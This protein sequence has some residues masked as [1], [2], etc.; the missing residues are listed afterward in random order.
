[1]EG[2]RDE[3]LRVFAWEAIP[4]LILNDSFICAVFEG[5]LNQVMF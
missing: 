4:Y 1:M 5:N 2:T 3:A